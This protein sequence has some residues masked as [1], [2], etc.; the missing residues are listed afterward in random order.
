MVLLAAAAS[1]SIVLASFYRATQLPDSHKRNHV[2]SDDDGEA[3]APAECEG[4]C[5][6][7]PRIFI[8]FFALAT[9][10]LS[11]WNW[12]LHGHDAGLSIVTIAW[13]SYPSRCFLTCLTNFAVDHRSGFCLACH[14][15]VTKAT[16]LHYRLANS[17]LITYIVAGVSNHH[18]QGIPES[19]HILGS[20]CPRSFPCLHMLFFAAASKCVLQR[21]RRRR[22]VHVFRNLEVGSRSVHK[23]KL[24]SLT[25]LGTLLHG[26]VHSWIKHVSLAGSNMMTCRHSG[27]APG[28]KI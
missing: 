18:T 4:N 21:Q 3:T 14:S 12:T 10:L 8:A 16:T 5:D 6:R 17:C 24:W 26:F 20:S 11:A 28:P 2:Y 1:T 9:S 7:T 22:T 27:M 13:V 15:I 19:S 25:V 23:L